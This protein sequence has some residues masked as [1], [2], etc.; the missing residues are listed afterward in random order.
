MRTNVKEG[1]MANL[2][3]TYVS[4][5]HRDHVDSGCPLPAI[6]AEVAR[7]PLPL[8]ERFTAQLQG[9]LDDIAA[10]LPGTSPERKREKARVLITS[11][12]GAVMLARA[13]AD[14]DLSTAI[15]EATH[16]HLLAFVADE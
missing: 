10:A 3:G 6:S 15:L 14:Q 13:I 16:K 9:F 5:H 1:G 12:V 7:H 11:M 2:I 8:R 4:E